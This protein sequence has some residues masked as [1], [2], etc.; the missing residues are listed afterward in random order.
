MPSIVSCPGTDISSLNSHIQEPGY[1]I[2]IALGYGLDD[3]GFESRQ[4]LGIFLLTTSS[5]PAL[6]PTQFPIQWV[7]AV[8]SLGVKLLLREA[9]HPSPSGAAVKECMEL[10]LHSP[11]RLNC[12]IL[13]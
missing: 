1:L 11:I 6:R 3:R 13:S 5:R 10:Y 2:V 12:V 4:G 7:P 9:V 8:F